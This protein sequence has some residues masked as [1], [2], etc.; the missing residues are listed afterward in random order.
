MTTPAP[1]LL[2]VD[3]LSMWIVQSSS[4]FSSCSGAVN[5]AIKSS[6]AWAF[7]S[8]RGDIVH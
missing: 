6:S 7:R 2:L 5:S 8:S 1:P 3:D 4:W